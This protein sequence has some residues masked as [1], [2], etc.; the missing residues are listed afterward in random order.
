MNQY[1]KKRI[2]KKAYYTTFRGEK[3]SGIIT[4]FVFYGNIHAVID[5]VNISIFDI[6]KF[7]S[8]NSQLTIF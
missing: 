8:V 2:G 4:D 7:E 6:E 1:F 5:G 3:K